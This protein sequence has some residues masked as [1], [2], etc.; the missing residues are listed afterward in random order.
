VIHSN[1]R[2]LELQTMQCTVEFLEIARRKLQMLR[3]EKLWALSVNDSA[4]D[5]MGGAIEKCR[6]IR[7]IQ[8]Y[9]IYNHD[10][11]T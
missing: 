5:N 6:G 10:Y 2:V 1:A 8:F 11:G 4:I 3:S 7:E 9:Y